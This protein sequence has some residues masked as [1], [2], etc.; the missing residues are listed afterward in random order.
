M[1]GRRKPNSYIQLTT[2]CG[3]IKGLRQE[4]CLV[5]E[6][7]KYAEAGRWEDPQV[8]RGWEGVYDAT[9]RGPACCQHL[10]FHR[11]QPAA[12]N[13]FYYN[14]NAEKQIYE[15]SEEDGL[16]LNIWAPEKGENLPVA[17]FVH[18]GSFV[19]GSNTSPNIFR[20]VD[21]CRRGSFW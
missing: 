17:V 6:G 11:R 20:G 18:G 5:F 8:I 2:S 9:R 16:N 12:F 3:E 15:Y 4:G 10:Q 19:S 7:V 13:D 21:Y 1:R 14:E